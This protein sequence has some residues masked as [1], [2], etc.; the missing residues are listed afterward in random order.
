MLQAFFIGLILGFVFLFSIV[1][2][3]AQSRIFTIE[4]GIKEGEI[5]PHIIGEGK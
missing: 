5:S 3:L 4:Y 1:G 2:M